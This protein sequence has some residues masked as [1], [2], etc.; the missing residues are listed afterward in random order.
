MQLV[1]GTSAGVFGG[2]SQQAAGI[3]SRVVRQ[4][5]RMD[6]ELFA[7]AADGVYSSRDGRTWS[8]R[9]DTAG[10]EVW[11]VAASPHQTGVLYAGTAPAHLY[12]SRDMGQSWSEVAS[13][14]ETP[15]VERWC[16]PGNP[17]GARALAFAF[18]PF[19]PEHLWAGVEVGGV[20]A[21][22]DGGSHWDGSWVGPNADVHLLAPHPTQKG[23]LFATCGFGRN[24]GNPNEPGIAGPYRSDDGGKTWQHL[25]AG[26]D[27]HYTRP[28]CIDPRS[29]YVLTVPGVP[30]VRSSIKDPGGSQ[31]VLY[32]SEDN[33]AT[34][35]SLGDA[36]HSPSAARLTAIAHDPEVLSGVVVGTET[37]E[38]W[39]VSPSAE[40]TCVCDGLPSV[41]A[42]LAL[43]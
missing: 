43:E 40:W 30:D 16:V 15:G 18:D 39:R 31:C 12:A 8:S 41:Q 19:A 6:G 11:T 21:S 24:D 3:G 22:L 9:L 20:M 25:A 34:W 32:R 17:S 29:P 37:G 23:V 28:L 36:S 27:V 14:L 38:V 42:L 5:T 13:F 7:A 2:D 33:G 26:M 1:I 35:H 10:A 4:F